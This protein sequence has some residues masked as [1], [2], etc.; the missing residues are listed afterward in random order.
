MFDDYCMYNTCC[1]HQHRPDTCETCIKEIRQRCTPLDAKFD[2]LACKGLLPGTRVKVFD[3]V[4]YKNDKD[5]PL[6]TTVRDATVVL[7]YGSL[8][9][10]Y[11]SS[12]TILGPYPSCVDVIFDHRPERVSHGHF[13]CGIT[14]LE[15]P[16]ELTGLFNVQKPFGIA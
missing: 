5:T 11:N 10:I 1:K 15:T 13:T 8:E 14:L 12:L 3:H 16:I 9:T 6:D 2:P 7:H 4:L